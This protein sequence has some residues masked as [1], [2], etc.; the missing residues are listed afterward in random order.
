MWCWN[1]I[2]RALTKRSLRH[3]KLLYLPFRVVLT[4]EAVEHSVGLTTSRTLWGGAF[5]VAKTETHLLVY[6]ASDN[7]I[8]IPRRIFSTGEQYRAFA[9]AAFRYFRATRPRD[10]KGARAGLPR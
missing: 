8:I 2:V 6:F 9:D 7:A 3:S 10:G 5:D 1:P 4:P